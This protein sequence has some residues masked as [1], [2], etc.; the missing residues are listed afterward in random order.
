MKA[1]RHDRAHGGSGLRNYAPVHVS[2]ARTIRSHYAGVFDVDAERATA[3]AHRFDVP[4]VYSSWADVL[5]DSTVDAVDICLPHHL[6]HSFALE[7]LRAGKH[8][9]V[10]KPLAPTVS[11]GREMVAAAG[12]AK[13]VLMPVHNRDFVPTLMRLKEIAA[14]GALGDVYLIKT[15]GIEPPATVGVGPVPGRTSTGL[16]GVA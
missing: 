14:G 10:E 7:A 4:R 5:A 3:V 8:V 11:Q 13:R 15:L 6:H 1:R 16:V 12:Q 9:L 2:A